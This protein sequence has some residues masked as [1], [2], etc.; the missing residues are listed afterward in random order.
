MIHAADIKD[1]CRPL[2]L[3]AVYFR[4]VAIAMYRSI[5]SAQ[6]LVIDRS[7]NNHRIASATHLLLGSDL[8]ARKEKHKNPTLKSAAA[9]ENKNQLI[10]VRRRFLEI[11]RYI[12]KPFPRTV[13]R[14]KIPPTTQN[15]TGIVRSILFMRIRNNLIILMVNHSYFIETVY[16]ARAKRSRKLVDFLLIDC[17]SK[18]NIES[19]ALI[20]QMKGY[21]IF[22]NITLTPGISKHSC[23]KC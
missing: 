14:E 16:S 19:R 3:K 10:V 4:G 12:T 1:K 20:G 22:I 2:A 23:T 11:M 21:A 8:P 18:V 5:V 9:S 15:Q 6:R 13:N 7:R 17:Y